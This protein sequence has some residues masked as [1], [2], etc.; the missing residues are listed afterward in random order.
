LSRVL[1]MLRNKKLENP[2]KKH[3]NIPL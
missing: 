1:A 2:W 3:D